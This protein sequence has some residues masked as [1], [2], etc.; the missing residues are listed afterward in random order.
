MKICYI[1]M[2]NLFLCP[3]IKKYQNY[4]GDRAEVDLIYWDRHG[5]DEDIKNAAHVYR[6]EKAMSEMTGRIRK[7]VQ[8]IGFRKYVIEII[9]KSKYDRI[10]FLHN[11][12]AL[13]MSGFISKHYKG[14][15]ILDIRDY[16]MENNKFFAAWEK[17]VINKSGMCVISSEGYKR[18]LPEYDYV[19]S[20]NDGLID[21]DIVQKFRL[22]EK[23]N[24]Y[25]QISFIGLV[26]FYEQNIKLMD[27]FCN[28]ARFRLGY[29]GQNSSVLKE[30]ADQQGYTNMDF[31]ERFD[32]A[33]TLD[34]YE[35]TQIINNYYGSDSMSLKYALSNK[36]YYAAQLGIPILVCK[37]TYMEEI[38]SKYQIGV[39][40]DIN[41]EKCA[42]KLK[43]YYDNIDW[44]KFNENCDKFLTHISADNDRF[45]KKLIT[46]ITN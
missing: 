16:S 4:I 8:F 15:Y 39:T 12:M 23:N 45:G 31:H 30:Y 33:N 37:N 44:Q 25:I 21:P 19:I 20:H 18:F 26:R 42:D 13:L 46:F 24:K 9:K 40:I 7:L 3:Y 2:T 1:S 17:K 34:F 38:S 36:L 5:V 22:C 10:I 11:Y 41:D 6:Y 35:K 27:A 14:R 29:Y 28:D 43:D 32:P